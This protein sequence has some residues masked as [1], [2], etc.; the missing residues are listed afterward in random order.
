M[1]K[2]VVIEVVAGEDGGAG[3]GDG[4]AGVDGGARLDVKEMV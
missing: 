1:A 2:H 4:E 3:I